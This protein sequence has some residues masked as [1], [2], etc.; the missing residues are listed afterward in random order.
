M[1][2]DV[3]NITALLRSK[4]NFLD[5]WEATMVDGNNKY[6]TVVIVDMARGEIVNTVATIRVYQNG[7]GSCRVLKHAPGG[8]DE[9]H[10]TEDFDAALALVARKPMCACGV[11]SRANWFVHAII[12]K[13][14]PGG[15]KTEYTDMYVCDAHFPTILDDGENADPDRCTL[16][17]EADEDW[18]NLALAVCGMFEFDKADEWEV[19]KAEVTHIR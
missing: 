9:V 2:M 1:A 4:R 5:S 11:P 18:E 15:T 3:V 17:T 10:T 14:V 13:N 6:F 7:A 8:P 12:G 19:L 16:L